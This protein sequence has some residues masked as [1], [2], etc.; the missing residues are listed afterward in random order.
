MNTYNTN[1]GEGDARPPKPVHTPPDW[2]RT[3]LERIELFRHPTGGFGFK[4][5]GYAV[6]EATL[7][8]AWKSF[9]R[10]VDTLDKDGVHSAQ[11]LACTPDWD[12]RP[13]GWRIA[14]GRCYKYFAVHRVLPITIVNPEAKYNFRYRLKAALDNPRT[15]H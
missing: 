7:R 14:M 13:R 5:G 10:G 6:T 2:S 8:T 11:D 15:I 3:A 4:P 12:N 9:W 1:E